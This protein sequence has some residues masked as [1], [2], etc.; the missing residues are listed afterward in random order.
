MPTR[1]TPWPNGTPCWIDYGASDVKAAEDFYGSLFGW[2]FEDSG[3]EF[4]TYHLATKNG[5]QVCGFAPLS[6]P[7]DSPAWTTYLA[8]DDVEAA[9]ER[10]RQAGGSVVVE[11]MDLG[12]IGKMLIALDSDGSGLGV[13]QAGERTGVRLYNEPGSLIWNEAILEDPV[14]ARKFYSAV[15]GHTFDKASDG[16]GHATFAVDGS[17]AG[18]VGGRESGLPR[19]W[20]VCFATGS[21]EETAA[22]AEAAGGKVTAGRVDT[23]VGRLAVLEDPWGGA[24]S[25][26]Q[27][28]T[29]N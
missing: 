9:A 13:W 25:V 15:F 23:H 29:G 24:F 1:S 12:P 21:V 28:P 19:G 17:P 14:S 11:P 4:A 6:T 22:K 16:E 5:E 10:I 8:A 3:A 2:E 27:A 7:E 20:L 26:V 18:G